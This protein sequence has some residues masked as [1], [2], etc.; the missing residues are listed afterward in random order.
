[1]V[2]QANNSCGTIFAFYRDDEGDTEKWKV[3]LFLE[4][5]RGEVGRMS[6]VAPPV[7]IREELAH[8][9]PGHLTGYHLP[10]EK[11]SGIEKNGRDG[12]EGLVRS[13]GARAPDILRAARHSS[14]SFWKGSSRDGILR[15]NQ[16]CENISCSRISFT[17][18]IKRGN[19]FEIP[20][21]N[22][23]IKTENS[24]KLNGFLL[25]RRT[26]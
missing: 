6:R 22:A 26:Y 5:D 10:K 3:R 23:R 16:T 25:I 14:S 17:F 19:N 2:V 7:V 1:M 20:I 8:R 9:S 24:S 4:K 18:Y 13:A 11:R 15:C 12:A 21:F